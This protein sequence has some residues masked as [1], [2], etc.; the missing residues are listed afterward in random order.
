MYV[1]RLCTLLPREPVSHSYAMLALLAAYGFRSGEV[2]GLTLDDVDWEHER[3]HPPR[4][5][6]RRVGEYPLVPRQT[7]STPN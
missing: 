1:E 5:K 3:I 4:P 7:A 6:Q 2:R